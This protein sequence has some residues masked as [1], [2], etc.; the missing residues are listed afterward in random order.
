MA[1]TVFKAARRFFHRFI[2]YHHDIG[3]KPFSEPVC[4]DQFSGNI[5]T[6][7]GKVYFVIYLK[8]EVII[9]QLVNDFIRH[10]RSFNI[11]KI[12]SLYGTYLLSA[13][14]GL[15]DFVYIFICQ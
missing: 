13:P 7:L 8:Y 10:I 11:K 12:H 9:N 5:L 15:K 3:K 6:L 1:Q 14:Y 2:L 4:P